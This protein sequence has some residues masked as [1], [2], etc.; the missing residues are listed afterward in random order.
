VT[1]VLRTTLHN[2]VWLIFCSAIY[3]LA[4]WYV[5]SS[6]PQAQFDT[7]RNWLVWLNLSIP[8]L[9]GLI[10]GLGFNVI[11]IRH[12]RRPLA[13]LSHQVRH[14][15]HRHNVMSAAIIL[16]L[17]PPV[18][19][20]FLEMKSLI[21]YLMPH[22]WDLFFSRLDFW[23]FGGRH[24]YEYLEFLIQWPWLYRLL[25]YI[26]HGLWPV[27]C[28]SVVAYSAAISPESF[29]KSRFLLSFFLSW[30][31][32]GSICAIAFDSGGPVF[33]REYTGLATYDPLVDQLRRAAGSNE[34]G[35]YG[36]VQLLKTH[37]SP[38]LAAPPGLGI[39]AMPSMHVSAAFLVFLHS[40]VAGRL[41]TALGLV[42][43]A[44]IYILSI[45]LGWHYAVDGLASIVLTLGIWK[46][47]GL[48]VNCQPS[49]PRTTIA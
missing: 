26:Y 6:T 3:V 10:I 36:L 13:H 48:L 22:K 25:S 32:V 29:S 17:L 14:A 21:P 49:A 20:Y 18:L 28:C 11:V 5:V 23:I 19:H 37:Q 38:S 30:I 16:F 27:V 2:H 8:L 40:R 7:S 31:I 39:S 12:P 34:S 45:A 35:A 42:Y 24:P 4:S 15:F 9:I 41:A 47:A 44:V 1:P 43:F 33:F 46:L